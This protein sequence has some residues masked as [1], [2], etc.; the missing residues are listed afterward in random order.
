MK[1]SSWLQR[2]QSLFELVLA[3]GVSAIMIVVIVS[4][5]NNAVQGANFSRNQT[6]AV[7][8]AES[9][10]E[11]LRFQRDTN[12]TTFLANA[13]TAPASWCLKDSPLT[14]TS[15]NQH[16]ACATTD[17]IAGT[18][19]IRQVDF[20]VTAP[21]GKTLVLANVTVTWTDSK[22]T[23]KITNATQFTDWRQR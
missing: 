4:L 13:S 7:R 17:V 14:D 2:G 11:W 5:V 18:I 20:T 22:G 6:S 21:A 23:H 16:S 12:L 9:G 19:F 15:W 3:I 1:K 8:Y 10:S